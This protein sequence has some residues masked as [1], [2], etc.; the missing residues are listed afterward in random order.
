MLAN[1]LLFETLVASKQASK[2]AHLQSLL[3]TCPPVQTTIGIL[4]GTGLK[5]GQDLPHANAIVVVL[6]ICVFVT[7]FAWSWGP[8]GWLV[9][10]E[11]FPLE[12]R[13]A[14]QSITVCFNLL[15]TATIAQAFLSMLCGMKY[16]I[17]L[18]FAGWIVVMTTFVYFF[19]P[20][21]KGIPIEEMKY[22]W[23]RHWFWKRVVPAVDDFGDVPLPTLK[24]GGGGGGKSNGSVAVEE[25][26]NE[27]DRS[28]LREFKDGVKS[29]HKVHQDG[30][31]GK[32]PPSS[33]A[34]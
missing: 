11:I 18:F 8:L 16:G 34:R 17:F 12:T 20:E 27:G 25:E 19:V 26:E 6:A 21:T 28:P 30:G 29:H 23:R 32:Y 2:Q 31:H 33:Y 15:F 7:G 4:L 24:G 22:V 10:S 5:E 9:P 3:P 14:G 13:S 1:W